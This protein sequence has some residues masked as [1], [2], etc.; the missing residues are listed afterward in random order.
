MR[1]S[2]VA[3]ILYISCNSW[4]DFYA[5]KNDPRISSITRINQSLLPIASFTLCPGPFFEHGIDFT[6]DEYG[7]AC[8]IKPE[9]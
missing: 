7:N 3:V 4:I 8:E 5:G 9:H 6:A 1:C 2:V